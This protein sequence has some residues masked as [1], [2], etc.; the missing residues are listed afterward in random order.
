VASSAIAEL[1]LN[2]NLKSPI[3]RGCQVTAFMADCYSS[4]HLCCCKPFHQSITRSQAK[5]WCRRNSSWLW[6]RYTTSGLQALCC[7]AAL[8]IVSVGFNGTLLAL[9]WILCVSYSEL[10]NNFATWTLLYLF[11]PTIIITLDIQQ[12]G[13]LRRHRRSARRAW[14]RTNSFLRAKIFHIL[15]DEC[16]G[17]FVV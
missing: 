12:R 7:N 1:L 2:I 3:G 10:L 5:Y 13:Q 11:D 17:L 8:D 9:T 14:L 4:W 15:D 6:F 16:K